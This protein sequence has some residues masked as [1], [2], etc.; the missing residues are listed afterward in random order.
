[1]RGNENQNQ[2]EEEEHEEE[3]ELVVYAS[4][5]EQ[6]LLLLTSLQL[7][8]IT[9]LIHRMGCRCSLWD[10]ANRLNSVLLGMWRVISCEF[11]GF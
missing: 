1:M 3:E 10:D 8:V 9:V 11:I 4:R 6:V 7:T 2:K 5:I